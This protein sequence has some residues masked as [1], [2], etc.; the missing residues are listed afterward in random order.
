MLFVCSAVRNLKFKGQRVKDLALIV[1]SYTTAIISM[2]LESL[3]R[4]YILRMTPKERGMLNGTIKRVFSRSALARKVRDAARAESKGPRGGKQYTCA[5]CGSVQ[6]LGK[7]NVDHRDPVIPVGKH[8]SE[9]SWHQFLS[10]LWCSE[11]NLQVLC[12]TCHKA[13]SK[14]E[15]RVRKEARRCKTLEL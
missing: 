5:A 8:Y 13:K 15:A 6:G 12:V 2:G 3:S 4:P 10:R 7:I 9:L 1:T 11:D 14:E